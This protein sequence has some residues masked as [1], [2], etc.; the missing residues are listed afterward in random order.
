MSVSPML[1]SVLQAV[2][3][4][5]NPRAV[6][7]GSSG[8]AGKRLQLIDIFERLHPASGLADHNPTM[9]ALGGVAGF[10]QRGPGRDETLVLRRRIRQVERGAADLVDRFNA[11]L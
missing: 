6:R 2:G 7:G 4:F 3:G 11:L 5:R 1:V 8:V 9:P 10:L